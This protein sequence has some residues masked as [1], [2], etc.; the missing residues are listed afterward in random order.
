MDL[1][2]QP[3]DIKIKIAE[4]IA[5]NSQVKNISQIGTKFL[6]FCGKYDLV[7]LSESATKMAE[8]MSAGYFTTIPEVEH[9][10]Q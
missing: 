1:S 9:E 4:T 7:K 5:M 8:W 10:N 2:A 3:D 6:K